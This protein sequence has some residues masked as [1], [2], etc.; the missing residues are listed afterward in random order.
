MIQTSL[1]VPPIRDTTS[2]L[3]ILLANLEVSSYKDPTLDDSPLRREGKLAKASS[4][5]RP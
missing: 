4:R 2:M 5:V 3:G 1:I